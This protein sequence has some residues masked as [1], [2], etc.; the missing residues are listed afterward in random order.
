MSTHDAIKPFNLRRWFALLS[1]VVIGF[2]G[3]VNAW[4]ITSFLNNHLFQRE[5]LVSREFVQNILVSDGSLG[6]LAHPDDA[7]LKGRFSDT[8]KHLSNMRDV[9]RANVYGRDGVVLWSSDPDLIGKRFDDNDELEDAMAGQL[10]VHSGHIDRTSKQEHL[11]LH[12]AT[13]FFVESYIP[14]LAPENGRVVGVVELYKAPLALTEA[15]NEGRLQVGLAAVAGA[16]AL[17]LCLFGLIRRADALIHQQHARLLESETLAVVGEL[18]AS[19]AH[20]LRNPLSSI[21]SSAEL[22]LESPT[23]DCSEP[24]RDI[25][26]EVDRITKRITQ[27]LRLS[28]RDVLSKEIVDLSELLEVCVEDHQQAYQL[29]GHTLE[30]ETR[31]GSAR[32]SAD[33]ALLQQVF[34]SL[35][36]NAAEAMVGPG[37]CRIA[38]G[39]EGDADWRIEISDEGQGLAPEVAAQVFRPFFTTKPQGLGLGL[40]IAKRI[41][42][43]FGG[44]LSIHSEP[45]HGSTVTIV[46]PG[47]AP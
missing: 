32:V 19:V 29:N 7:M 8:V 25:I 41:I 47:I 28:G 12:P 43:R 15:I 10:V 16:L 36:S 34:H 42:E 33:T 46:L 45:G 23:E 35:L 44:T 1:P 27:L 2:I 21:R 3:L 37:R 18:T 39:R 5:A 9:L 11:G 30:L 26:R 31:V 6:Y 13:Q 38:L 40:P 20:N 24:A 17:Y 4:V 22:A 14:I